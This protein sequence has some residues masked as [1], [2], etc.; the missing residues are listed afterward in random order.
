M[1][2]TRWLTLSHQPSNWSWKSA[3]LANRRPGS[4]LER[5]NRCDRSSTPF[6]CG[7]AAAR[8]TQP[9]PSWPQKPANAS[10]GRPPPAWIAPS[11]SQTSFSGSA[12]IRSSERPRPQSTSG[13][14]FEN[15][16]VPATT[17]DQHSSTV[18]T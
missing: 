1:R 3:S 12:P 9:T 14:S 7:S 6:A 4:K 11:R 2:W 10:V 18:T 5:M 16:S 15:T 17:R 13:G 8:I